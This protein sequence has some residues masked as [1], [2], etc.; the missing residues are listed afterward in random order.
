MDFNFYQWQIVELD[1]EKVICRYEEQY[2]NPATAMRDCL[3]VVCGE[4]DNSRKNELGLFI[5]NSGL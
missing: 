3:Y 5:K 4:I 1:T 2:T